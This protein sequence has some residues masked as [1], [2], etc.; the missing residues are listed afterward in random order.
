MKSNLKLVPE[1]DPIASIANRIKDG[2]WPCVENVDLTQFV[3]RPTPTTFNINLN[4]SLQVRTKSI[5]FK[6]VNRQVRKVEN[7]G[8]LSAL[9]DPVLIYFPTAITY[10][11]CEFEADTYALLDRNHGVLIK[12]TCGIMNSDAYIVRFDTD[13]DSKLSNIKA[14]GNCLNMV[15]E[16]KQSTEIDDVR[17]EYHELIDENIKAG[18]GPSLTPEQNAIFLKRYP[19]LH[20]NS[21]KNFASSHSEGGRKKPA[22][23]PTDPELDAA[24]KK[25]EKIYPNHVV[26]TPAQVAAWN[27]EAMGRAMTAVLNNDDPDRDDR[28]IVFI[29]YARTKTQNQERAQNKITNKLKGDFKDRFGFNDVVVIFMKANSDVVT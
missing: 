20:K 11:D 21:L 1:L 25:Y 19:F 28:N 26:S 17:N 14:L 15:W 22:W 29:F 24:F 18:L 9:Q 27:G 4:K 6:F 10:E 16:E 12:V 23:V 2:T 3:T 8:D 13:L 7:T 5:D